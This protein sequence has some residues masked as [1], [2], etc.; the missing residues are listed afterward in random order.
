ME[1]FLHVAENPGVRV[2]ELA[3]L[4]ETTDATASRASR[5]L[6][7]ADEPG[8]R[9]PGRGWLM[10]ASNGH[11]AVSRHFYL[12]EAGIELVQRL[13]ALIESAR[14][15]GVRA[16]P[17]ELRPSPWAVVVHNPDDAGG[18]RISSP[19][20]R[21][22]RGRNG[23]ACAP[24]QGGHALVRSGVPMRPFVLAATSSLLVMSAACGANGQTAQTAAP[25]APVETRPANGATQTPAFA[26]Q[27]RAPGVQTQGTLR[28]A[29]VAS[30]LV[31]PWGMA[32]LPDGNWLVTERPGRLR[33]VSAAWQV[34]EPITGL[35]AVDARG[36][37]G[38]LDVTL[39]PGFA[40]D[41]TI[42]WSYAEPRD[43]GNATSVAR[44]VLS[45]DGT[46]VG[47]VRVIFR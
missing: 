46:S 20:L 31:H 8:A 38:L 32:L 30:G 11:E 18:V 44:G 45:A 5:S 6:L 25:G 39:S 28:H 10:M 41:R 22:N 2:K 23:G 9:P 29:V 34:G 12:T 26:G 4:M 27:T 15:I 24:F 21:F 1:A 36:Q 47:D 35:P 42:F 14:P 3:V 37:G 17:A 13:D 40:A 16:A 7:Q 43:G 19:S 33:I